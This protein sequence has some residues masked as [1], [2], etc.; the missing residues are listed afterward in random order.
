M[1]TIST[2]DGTGRVVVKQV[3]LNRLLNATQDRIAFFGTKMF[4]L[5]TKF[6][7]INEW[8][9]CWETLIFPF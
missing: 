2:I 8:G 3:I 6:I 1:M 4:M 5:Y 9:A 7:E